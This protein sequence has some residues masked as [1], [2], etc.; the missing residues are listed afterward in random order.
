MDWNDTLCG[1][2]ITPESWVGGVVDSCLGWFR[3]REVDGIKNPAFKRCYGEWEYECT[4]IFPP[5]GWAGK[6]D[7]E[8]WDAIYRDGA[9][10]IE[11]SNP[12][13]VCVHFVGCTPR[14]LISLTAY[15]LQSCSH[16]MIGTETARLHILAL[17]N[18]LVLQRRLQE[19]R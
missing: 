2:K 12:F 14:G 6:S 8:L 3:V 4:P 18:A 7:A 1:E 13:Y 10:H 15:D 17:Q 19:Q 11:V 9:C 16:N 5:R